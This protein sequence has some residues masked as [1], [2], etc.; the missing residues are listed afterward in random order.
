MK[1]KILSLATCACLITPSTAL[2]TNGAF[3]IG[4][5]AKQRAVGGAAI[6]FPQGALTGAANPANIAF[7]PGGFDL[8]LNIF[9]PIRS[10]RFDTALKDDPNSL[11]LLGDEA[12]GAESESPYFFV[13]NVGVSWKVSPTLTAA[14]IVYANGGMNTD[15]ATNIYHQS[16]AKPIGLF[17]GAAAATAGVDTSSDEGRALVDGVKDRFGNAPNTGQL[18]VNLEQAIFA[19]SIA[20]QPDE[21]YAIGLSL[22][23]GFQRFSAQGLGD[24]VGFST[25]PSHVTNNGNSMAAGIGARLGVTARP[26]PWLTIGLA[27]ASKIYMTPFDDYAGLFAEQGDFDVPA[28]FGIGASVQPFEGLNLALDVTRIMYSGVASMGNDGPTTEEFL[29]GFNNALGNAYADAQTTDTVLLADGLDRALGADDGFGFGWQ[30]IWVVKVGAT[31]APIDALTLRAGYNY[32]QSPIPDDQV[33]FNMLAPGV[34]T[35]HYT[36]GLSYAINAH[37]EISA[38]YMWAPAQTQSHQYRTSGAP[39]GFDAF[40]LGYDTEIQ[41]EQHVAEL[42]YRRAF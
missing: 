40:V 16:F 30:D 39:F 33:L 26:V 36:G 41:M 28:N 9:A 32:G 5:G 11:G 6:G 22:L 37:N 3:G 29:G 35:H 7:V 23:M 14:V 27:G 31:Y 25:D 38:A 17:A 24:F 4:Y 2:A 8:S 18:G 34:T 19:P 15:Y 21:R 10:A 12:Y 1:S 20:W 42:A 13:P